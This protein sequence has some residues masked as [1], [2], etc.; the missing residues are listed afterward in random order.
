[1]S[2]ERLKSP[3]VEVIERGKISRVW[4]VPIVAFVIG[5]L[6]VWTRVY[7]PVNKSRG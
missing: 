1:M 6:V 7:K 3:K 5:G 4:I 2:D